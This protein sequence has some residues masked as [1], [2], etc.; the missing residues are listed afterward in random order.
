VVTRQKIHTGMIYP[1][2]TATVICENNHIRWSS[3]ARP[4]P[5]CPAP[6]AKSTATK[7]T[8]PINALRPGLPRKDGDPMPE[9]KL[10]V[11]DAAE[12]AETL[13]SDL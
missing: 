8:P 13:P 7:P 3:M 9:V 6:P 10:D 12:L 4:S 11:A 5:W 2:K 1:R